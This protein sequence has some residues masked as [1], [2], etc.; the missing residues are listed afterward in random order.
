MYYLVLPPVVETPPEVSTAEITVTPTV[1]P[2]GWIKVRPSIIR[3][4]IKA[5]I[6]IC[7]TTKLAF[8]FPR[9]V[10]IVCFISLLNCCAL[11]SC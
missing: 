11:I 3:I 7:L 4:I 1:E 2:H 6:I 8:L 9:L 5:I 10:P